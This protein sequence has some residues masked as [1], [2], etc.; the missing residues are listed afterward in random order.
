ML[1]EECRPGHTLDT[2]AP[3]EADSAAAELLQQLQSAAC[4][5]NLPRLADRVRD[6]SEDLPD[7]WLALHEPFEQSLLEHAA[8]LLPMLATHDER[9]MLHGDFHHHNI[10]AAGNRQ[11]LAIDPL[12]AVGDP[13][14]DAVQYLLFR[15]GGLAAP[16]IEWGAVNKEFCSLI[17]VD[18]ERVKAWIFVRLITDAQPRSERGAAARHLDAV[19]G[20]LWTARLIQRLRN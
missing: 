13:A 9:V 6:L 10:L 2:L 4:P 12:P 19:H 5:T 18:P 7:R 3:R 20:D 8:A 17:E 14:Y 11:W 16:Q 1:I 15:K